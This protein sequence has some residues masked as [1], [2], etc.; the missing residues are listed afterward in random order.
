MLNQPSAPGAN[1]RSATAEEILVRLSREAGFNPK[2]YP[3]RDARDPDLKLQ[4]TAAQ[5]C[6]V[7]QRW[8]FYDADFV[9]QIR[10]KGDSDW[11]K[12]FVFAHE[13]A[14][15]FNNDPDFHQPNQEKLADHAAALWL[16]HMGA[17]VQDLVRAINAFVINEKRVGE[18]PSRCERVAEVIQAHNEVTQEY[19]RM[20]L[21]R[22]LY[23][24]RNCAPMEWTRSV[25]VAPPD[26][27]QMSPGVH[28]R[29]RIEAK[30]QIAADDVMKIGTPAANAKFPVDFDHDVAGMCAVSA[31]TIGDQL[32]WDNIGV[33]ALMK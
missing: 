11:P 3:L 18:Y 1:P 9:E 30:A 19:N 32:T 14:H 13:V 10:I 28:A 6:N 12:Y 22:P 17:S 7:N 33:C 24:V 15:H 27:S 29:R 31:I 20:G 5:T 26:V 23:E 16:T 25:V 4:G 8:I 2:S 21:D